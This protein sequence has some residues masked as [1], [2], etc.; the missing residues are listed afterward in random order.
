M[1]LAPL[2]LKHP[3]GFLVLLFIRVERSLKVF[4]VVFGFFIFMGSELKFHTWIASFSSKWDVR[5]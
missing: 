4:P 1:Y 5:S 3:N 2:V